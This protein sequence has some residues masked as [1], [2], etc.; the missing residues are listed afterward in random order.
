M[1]V[2]GAQ[3]PT[4]CLSTFAVHPLHCIPPSEQPRP[5]NEPLFSALDACLIQ[6]H[7]DGVEGCSRRFRQT[8]DAKDDVRFQEM[9]IIKTI[10]LSFG[11]ELI[12][13]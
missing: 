8:Q 7:P 6:C 4:M 1:T 3:A 5:L 12:V 11:T 2:P 10:I 9:D 13:M